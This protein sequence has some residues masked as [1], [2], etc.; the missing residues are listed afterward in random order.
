MHQ[1]KGVNCVSLIINYILTGLIIY[2]TTL[3]N[4]VKCDNQSD[5]DKS[6]LSGA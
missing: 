6:V 3:I 1:M 5:Y 2:E 4:N